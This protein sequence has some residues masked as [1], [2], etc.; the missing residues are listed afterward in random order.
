M[1][2]TKQDANEYK[3]NKGKHSGFNINIYGLT[4]RED[5]DIDLLADRIVKKMNIAVAGGV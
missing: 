2:L 1:L 3:N 4:V 5:A